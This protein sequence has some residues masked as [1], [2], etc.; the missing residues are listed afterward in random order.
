MW[1]VLCGNTCFVKNVQLLNENNNNMQALHFDGGARLRTPL[2]LSTCEGLGPISTIDQLLLN[3]SSK[4]HVCGSARITLTPANFVNNCWL[5]NVFSQ[6]ALFFFFLTLPCCVTHLR[7][8]PLSDCAARAS[9]Y[10]GQFSW[11]DNPI[12]TVVGLADKIN[13]F[14]IGHSSFSN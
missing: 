9:R 5:P 4:T 12:S 13:L 3:G 1:L 11:Q 7:L 2:L 8:V 10:L 6:K 14:T